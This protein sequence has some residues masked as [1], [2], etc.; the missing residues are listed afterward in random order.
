MPLETGRQF[1][2]AIM[3]AIVEDIKK[4]SV[5]ERIELVED[6]WN[7]I[8]E[9]PRF[10]PNLSGRERE[11]LHRRYSAHQADLSKSIPWEQVREKIFSGV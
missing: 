10:S 1:H 3:N 4:L 2:G 6:I 8:A 9:E 7:S 11:E 5:S